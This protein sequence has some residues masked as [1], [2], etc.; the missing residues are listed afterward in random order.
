VLGYPALKVIHDRLLIEAKRKLIYSERPV[1]HIAYELGFEDAA[2]FAR[3]FAGRAGA[4]PSQYRARM[5][6]APRQQQ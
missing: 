2:Y 5:S 3:F 1:S 6:A 4:S